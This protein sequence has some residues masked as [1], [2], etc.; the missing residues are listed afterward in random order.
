ML[1][2]QERHNSKLSLNELQV[3]HLLFLQL[4]SIGSG[5]IGSGSVGSGSIGGASVVSGSIGG[6]S[7]G[8]SCAWVEGGF[9][10]SVCTIG[11]S[12]L[13]RTHSPCSSLYSLLHCINPFSS[14]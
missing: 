7:V 1:S 8:S 10:S 2:S 13:I 11:S 9:I 14:L 6:A 12:T 5:S 4:I 3:E